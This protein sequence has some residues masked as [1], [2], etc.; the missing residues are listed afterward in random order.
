MRETKDGE[1]EVG[2]NARLANESQS[3]HG[4][5]HG[6][7]R[8]RAQIVMRILTH[9]DPAKEDTHDPAQVDPFRQGVRNVDETHH[10]G[11]LQTGVVIEIDVFED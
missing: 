8:H 5:L 7:L 2:E 11:E 9:D 6:D 1:S 10:H 4:L 3:P